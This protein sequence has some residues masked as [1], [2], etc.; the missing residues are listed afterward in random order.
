MYDN[1]LLSQ[2]YR[3]PREY[4]ATVEWWLKG[5]HRRTKKNLTSA[6]SFNINLTSATSFNINL[7]WSHKDWTRVTSSEIRGYSHDIIFQQSTKMAFQ[8]AQA[9]TL[10]NL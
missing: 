1:V 9:I 3:T 5:K 10:R 7:T 4:G 8:Y 6:T 2:G